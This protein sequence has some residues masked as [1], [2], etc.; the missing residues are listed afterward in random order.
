M[1]MALVLLFCS[2]GT[3]ALSGKPGSSGKTL[4]L[5]VV[6]KN[7]VYNAPTTQEVLDSIFSEPQVGLNQPE[8]RFEMVQILPSSF[9]NNTMFQAHRNILILEVDP[10]G[11]NKV[12]LD[13]DV[14]ASPQVVVRITATDMHSL[15]SM[16]LVRSERL[17]DKYYQ[18]E[19]R[20]MDKVFSQTPDIKI[21]NKIKD[22]Y[23]FRLSIPEEFTYA[24]QQDGFTWVRKEAKDFSLQLF[25]NS[26]PAGNNPAL[27]E[28]SILNRIDTMLYRYVPGPSEGSYPGVER[29]DFFYTRQVVID[30]LKAVETRGLWR[31]YN[32]FMSGPFVCYTF[33][34]PDGNELLT[35]MGC[36]YS[37]S[38]RS[39][40]MMKRDLLMQVDG[41]CRSIRYQK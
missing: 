33:L 24:K 17:L 14:W 3:P 23:G 16:L 30:S 13:K 7:T 25:I 8:P 27:D 4:E 28:A 22:T 20:R 26:E 15:D 19:Y 18:Q 10:L 29:R 5:M 9:E 40:M 35:L 39:K 32:D 41:I 1:L 31:T 38:Q 21:I 37:P 12:F 36:V 2:C 6:A 34:S 11:V